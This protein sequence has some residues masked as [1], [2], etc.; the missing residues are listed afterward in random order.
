MCLSMAYM[1]LADCKPQE[2]DR[3]YRNLDNDP[4]CSCKGFQEN[5]VATQTFYNCSGCMPEDQELEVAVAA[6]LKEPTVIQ[7]LKG[8]SLTKVI[9]AFGTKP[10]VLGC[11]VNRPTCHLAHVQRYFPS[12][13][14]EG[15]DHGLSL[16]D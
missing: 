3:Q 14:H 11:V 16:Q 9:R 15:A 1:H 5:T 12:H 8:K 6:G 13:E 2:Q 7:V 4:P 10:V